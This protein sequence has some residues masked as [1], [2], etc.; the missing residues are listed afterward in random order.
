[1]GTLWEK[2]VSTVLACAAVA[3]VGILVRREILAKPS[4]ILQKGEYAKQWKSFAE[5]GRT[6]GDPKAPI[7]IVEF[8]EMQC[9]YCKKFHATLKN[10]ELKFPNKLSYTFVHFPSES[11]LHAFAASR[12][13]ECASD[14]DRFRQF[15]DVAFQNQSQLGKQAWDWFALQAGVPDTAVFARCMFSTA[16]P[17]L[18]TAGIELGKHLKIA[19]T[20]TFFLNGW[21]MN[22]AAPDSQVVRMVEDLLAHRKPHP[23]YPDD[24]LKN[25]L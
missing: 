24:A 23:D 25:N 18:V 1:M 12:A 5:S 13:A 2:S 11:H 14:Q 7:S 21:R 20:P 17:P 6:V 9:P 19:G 4:S 8:S 22:G 3:M 10:L 15:L 16:T